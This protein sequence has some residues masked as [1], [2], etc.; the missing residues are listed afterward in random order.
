LSPA[1]FPQES[2]TLKISS[3][4]HF[5]KQPKKNKSYLKNKHY[6]SKRK[7][8]TALTSKLKKIRNSNNTSLPIGVTKR[9]RKQMPKLGSLMEPSI[10]SK[11]SSSVRKR[12]RM[13][14]KMDVKKWRKSLASQK[15]RPKRINKIHRIDLEI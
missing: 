13:R 9:R 3:S 2:F 10:R 4:S 7:K 5:K 14:K 1:T 8:R 12:K 6:S 11:K 15:R